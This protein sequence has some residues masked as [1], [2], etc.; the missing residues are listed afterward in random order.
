[1]DS[2][3]PTAKQLSELWPVVLSRL[4]KITEREDPIGWYGDGHLDAR[5][6]RPCDYGGCNLTVNQEAYL[7]GYNDGKR[8]TFENGNEAVALRDTYRHNI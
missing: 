4:G 7:R 6:G 8:D 2:Y 5:R 3:G 1:M